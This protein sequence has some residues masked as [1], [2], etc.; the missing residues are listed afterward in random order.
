MGKHILAQVY[1]TQY[2][3][4]KFETPDE[5]ATR[6][7]GVDDKWVYLSELSSKKLQAL[8]DDLKREQEKEKLRIEF[9]HHASEFNRWVRDISEN[10]KL[11]QFGF[12]LPEVESFKTEL[13]KLNNEVRS[14]VAR[15]KSEYEAVDSQLKQMG[16]T[17]NVYTQDTLDTLAATTKLLESAL[18]E[19]NQAYATELK[20]QQ[21]NDTLCKQFADLVEPLSKWVSENKSAIT[22]NKATLEEQLRLVE[23][24]L[25]NLA[26]DGASLTQIK[27]LAETITSK[28]ITHNRHTNLTL[29][30]IEVQ[31]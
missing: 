19:R 4:W 25:D 7:K 17:E 30:D 21:A 12:T 26:I 23:S 13:D 5:I 9:S 8:Q 15:R 27:S 24:R 11:T 1:T 28:N 2:S 3:N 14:E 22:N 6:E 31:W 18:E 20:K 16:V 10:S 29:T